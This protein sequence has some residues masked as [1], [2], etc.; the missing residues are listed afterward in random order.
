[1][2]LPANF[3]WGGAISAN[4][5]EG[6][7]DADERGITNFDML[8][9]NPTRL[10]DVVIDEENFLNQSFD[11]YSGRKGIDFYNR[12]K[13]DIQLLKDLGANSFRLSLSWSRIFPQGDEKEPNEKGIV[14][15]ERVL[16][17]LAVQG[18]EPIVTISHFDMPLGLIKK[19]GGW[20]NREIVNFYLNYSETVMKRFEKYVRYWIPFN[21][22]NMTMHIPF[23]GAGLTFSS[24]ENRL[25]KKYQAAHH[26]LLANSMTIEMGRKINPNFQFGCMMAAGKTYALT[27]RP[28]DVFAAFVSDK[29]NFF[30]SDVQVKGTYPKTMKNYFANNG[31]HLKTEE[32]D[33]EILKQNTV[34]FLSFSYYASACSAAKDQDVEMVKTNGPDTIKNPYLPDT[35]S[36]WQVDPLGLRIT[37]N[38]LYDR[39][40][41]PL[42]IV[43]NGLGT[44]A[45]QMVDGKIRDDYRIDYMEKHLK[46][47]IAAVVEDGVE[48]M[49]YLSWG[50]IDL[51]SVSEGKMSKRY[52]VIYVDAD[53]KGNGTYDRYKK[54]SFYWYQEVIRSNG[55]IL[56]VEN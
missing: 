53:D 27:S 52:G 21:E 33:F 41:I 26:Q 46:N 25:E 37:L 44:Y 42:F 40:E 32:E 22:M 30:F 7:F 54:D 3:F 39:Y 48:L 24:D 15:Y 16:E 8:P 56:M 31:I 34:D 13:E 10:Q 17:E 4:Q 11:Y 49:G 9:M 51:V 1:M 20:Y 36:V 43:E 47:M 45:D 28:E 38:S 6:S 29:N 2:K 14:F 23:I 5:T 18:I 35:N 19:Y 55:Q 50:I 12:F